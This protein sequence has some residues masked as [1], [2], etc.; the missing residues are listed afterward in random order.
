MGFLWIWREL[1]A[2]AKARSPTN[3]WTFVFIAKPTGNKLKMDL[4]FILI[5]TGYVLKK[6]V[7]EPV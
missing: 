7:K 5:Y 1:C 3:A 4:F 2:P 6:N